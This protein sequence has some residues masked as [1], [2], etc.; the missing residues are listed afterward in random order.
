LIF[1]T[2]AALAWG[3]ARSSFVNGNFVATVLLCQSMVEQL[4]ASFLSSGLESDDL[5][6]RVTF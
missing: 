4:L 3:E 5:P 2:V 1:G 6:R